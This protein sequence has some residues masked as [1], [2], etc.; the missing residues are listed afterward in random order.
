LPDIAAT[1]IRV[2]ARRALVHGGCVPRYARLWLALTQA[3]RL[4]Y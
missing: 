1:F 2:G 4:S 3:V